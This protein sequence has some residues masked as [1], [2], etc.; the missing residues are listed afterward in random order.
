MV[1]EAAAEGHEPPPAPFERWNRIAVRAL[2][3]LVAICVVAT[4][5]A[6]GAFFWVYAGHDRLELIDDPVIEET[7][8][9]TCG[10]MAEAVTALAPPV[11]TS[12]S[13]SSAAIRAQN[14]AVLAMVAT[15]RGLGNRLDE[16]QPSRAWLADWE[17]LV[18]ARDT[19][20]DVVET[21][22]SAP[23]EVPQTEDGYPI[24]TRMGKAMTSCQVPASLVASWP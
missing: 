24:T 12:P 4:V 11:G 2:L 23:L 19:Q 7:A 21:G 17:T 1:H 14:D 5:L 3:G 22:S 13:R 20:A 18:Q 10:E 15:V 9:R 6:S 16:D 8:S